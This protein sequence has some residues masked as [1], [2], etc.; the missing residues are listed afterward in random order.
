MCV[1]LFLT[2][3]EQKGPSPPPEPSQQEDKEIDI[4]LNDPEVAG[5][6]LKIQAGFRGHK[7]R[8]KIKEMKVGW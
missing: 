4:D 7:S 2:L 6:A 1:V 3:Q 8:Q 5:A